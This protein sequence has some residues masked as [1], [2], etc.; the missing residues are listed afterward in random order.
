MYLVNRAIAVVSIKKP[1]QDWI[2]SIDR[3]SK[4]TLEAVN[5][6]S[7]TYLLPEHDTPDEL[8]LIIQDL[9]KEIFELELAGF[10]T[11][12]SRWPELSYKNFLDWFEVKVHSMLFDPYD[13]KIEKE[14]YRER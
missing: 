14:E 12:K 4:F 11:D 8:E 13:D 7:H 5:R 1:C 3:P 10:C 9:Y 6:E 2:N